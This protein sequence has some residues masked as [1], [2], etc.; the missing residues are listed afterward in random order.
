MTRARAQNQTHPEERRKTERSGP[1][2]GVEH[3]ASGAV[4]RRHEPPGRTTQEASAFPVT[5]QTVKTTSRAAAED[6]GFLKTLP[7]NTAALHDAH[8]PQ[9]QRWGS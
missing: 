4:R 8:V 9:H 5:N 6:K 7:V 2:S 1:S 3:V